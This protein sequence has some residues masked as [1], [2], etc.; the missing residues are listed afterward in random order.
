MFPIEKE[1]RSGYTV[2]NGRND[3]AFLSY[4]PALLNDIEMQ[5]SD[6]LVKELADTM[7]S[8][9]QLSALFSLLSP[10]DQSAFIQSQ[11]DLE[12]EH[13]FQ[14]SIDAIETEKNDA[15][16]SDSDSTS[17]IDMTRFQA[18]QSDIH[19]DYTDNQ[20]QDLQWLKDA[21]PYA[22]RRIHTLPISKRF[23]SELH[24]YIMHAPHNYANKPGQYR[25]TVTWIGRP[26]STPSTAAYVPPVP[27]TLETGFNDL[28]LFIHS[29][30]E[31]HPLIKAALFHYQFEML[32]P[33]VD[34]NGRTGR[35][36][37]ELLLTNNHILPDLILDVSG[38]L[39]KKEF[40]YY[41]TLMSTEMNGT[42]EKWILFFVQV[43]HQAAIKAIE[44]IRELL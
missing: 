18:I 35:L 12:A 9:G 30:R 25:Y 1:N 14:L 10:S 27:D 19:P 32:H 15:A 43:H 40:A 33:F 3:S 31:L 21:Y 6:V 37:N 41:T 34:G 23:I 39:Q 4:Q 7:A 42:Y 13:S 11:T 44:R 17:L 26:G 36:L 2:E 28:E 5:Y 29:E 16:L 22:A 38:I 20:K 24:D 8:F